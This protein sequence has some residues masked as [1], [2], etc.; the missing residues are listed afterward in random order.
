[1]DDDEE[2]NSEDEKQNGEKDLNLLLLIENLEKTA[3]LF[4]N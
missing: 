4:I 3:R 2:E 1:M